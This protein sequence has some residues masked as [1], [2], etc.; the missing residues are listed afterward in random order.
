MGL[1]KIPTWSVLSPWRILREWVWETLLILTLHSTSTLQT[2]SFYRNVDP[3]LLQC[4]LSFSCLLLV[5]WWN[6]S[7]CHTPVLSKYPYYP[8]GKSIVYKRQ[9]LWCAPFLRITLRLFK[10]VIALE[11][12]FCIDQSMAMSY[13]ITELGYCAGLISRGSP[14]GRKHHSLINKNVSWHF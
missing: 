12:R 6:I 14:S 5:D 11:K 13:C 2:P 10:H 3:V 1:R 7:P 9:E 4:H 8:S